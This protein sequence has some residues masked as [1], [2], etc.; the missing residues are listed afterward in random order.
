MNRANFISLLCVLGVAVTSA[1][2]ATVS[3]PSAP[4]RDGSRERQPE[5]ASLSGTV[6]AADTGRPLRRALIR[7]YGGSVG[8]DGQ[9]VS[10]DASGRYEFTKLPPGRYELAAVRNGYLSLR[11]GQFRPFERGTP[12]QLGAG[13]V[14]KSVDFTLPRM[15]VVTGHIT[16]EANEPVAG[17]TVVPYR[18]A[19]FEGH[20]QLAPAGPATTTDDA[21]QYR[22]LNLSPGNYF[23]RASFRDTWT[24]S[25]GGEKHVL[26]YAPTYYP[27]TTALSS[28]KPV[29]VALGVEVPAIDLSLIPGRA[30]A[31]RGVAMDSTGTPLA[32]R[33]VSLTQEY[34]G[35]TMMAMST[36]GTAA[37]LPDGRFEFRNVPPGQY[38]A[39]VR[40]S[41]NSSS[42]PSQQG[43]AAVVTIDGIDID[44]LDLRTSSGWL[45]SGDVTTDDNETPVGNPSAFHIRAQSLDDGVNPLLT[46]GAD[47]GR[48]N[49][50][51]T[52]TISGLFG[53]ARMRPELPEGWYLKAV[54][55]GD[56][57]I[58]DEPLEAHNGELVE[59]V[60]VVV[61]QKM[62]S[63]D[64]Q[65]EAQPKSGHVDAT[66]IVFA[67]N[68]DRWVDDSRFI[69]SVRPDQSGRF[70]VSGLP[71]ERYLVVAV[72]YAE[73]GLWYEQD[74]LSSVQR[75]GQR[76]NLVDADHASV[77][78]KLR[79]ASA[80]R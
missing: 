35:P 76:V 3:R 67:E 14:I 19:F 21:G 20:R 61:S 37:V 27:G 38:K 9:S 55:R 1:R 39:L 62:A 26:G 57:E 8:S 31:I 2:Q 36:V 66:I 53:P 41:S 58:T 49:D 65:L 52:Y 71:A 44:D 25:E 63:I 24:V 75:Y 48:V 10:T 77:M 42:P 68:T 6:Y 46:A 43:A 28:G 56:K 51:W 60:R 47:S 40:A 80:G 45:V 79:Q 18:S 78:V 70:T 17:A 50:D 22:I 13:Q 7:L 69:R 4:T 59:G 12:L 15:S 73:D 11:Y 30:A 72:D 33:T 5:T 23:V 54:Y 34:R 64:G 16:D 74:F 32:G 29:S